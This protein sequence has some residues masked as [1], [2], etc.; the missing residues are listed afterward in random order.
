MDLCLA[1]FVLCWV[2]CPSLFCVLRMLLY[3]VANICNTESWN[4]V[5]NLTHTFLYG[6]ISGVYSIR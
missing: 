3:I 4:T 2:N 6:C 5:L 1:S